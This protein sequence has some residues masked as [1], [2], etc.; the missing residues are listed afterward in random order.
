MKP[1]KPR[2]VDGEISV[3]CSRT[4]PFGLRNRIMQYLRAFCLLSFNDAFFAVALRY[5]LHCK[6]LALFRAV[7]KIKV[8]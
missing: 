1:S 3:R 8:N 5:P 2:G 4:M 6:F 7:E